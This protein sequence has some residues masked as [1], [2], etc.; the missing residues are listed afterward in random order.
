MTFNLLMEVLPM[1]ST[2]EKQMEV[3]DRL[4]TYSWENSKAKCNGTKME[5]RQKEIDNLT[6]LIKVSQA[7]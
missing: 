4:K 3:C 5:T 7:A 6:N 2:Y 1:K